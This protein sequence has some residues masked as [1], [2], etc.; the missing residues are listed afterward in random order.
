MHGGQAFLLLFAIMVILN[1]PTFVFGLLAVKCAVYLCPSLKRFLVIRWVLPII[2]GLVLMVLGIGVTVAH[3]QQP[4]PTSPVLSGWGCL[5]LICVLD[6]GLLLLLA[7]LKYRECAGKATSTTAQVAE[8]LAGTIAAASLPPGLVETVER[9]PPVARTRLAAFR[10]G[11]VSPWSGWRY[12]KQQ[13]TLWRYGL[14]PLV[15]NLLVTGLVLAMLLAIAGYFIVAIHPKFADGWLGRTVEVLTAFGVLVFALGLSAL[16]WVILQGVFCGHFYA[17]LAE[18]VELRLGMAREDIREVRFSHQIVD[19]L[20][21]AGFLASVN[22]GLLL[23]HCVPGIG[24]VLSAAGSYYYTCMTLGLDYF[25]HPLALRGKRRGER[26]S[27][28]RQHRAHTLGLGT[29]VG[30]VFFVPSVNAVLLTTVVVGA[31]LLHRRLA[32]HD[33]DR[34]DGIG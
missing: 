7:W 20:N 10:E 34:I 8:E 27:F 1:V 25:E 12:M 5:A 30:M 3:L 26:L 6:L 23:L 4:W 16:A 18:Q 28:A 11:F 22:L 21:D 32:A 24:S 29:A 9:V 14:M 17:K 31:V 15:M 2:A 33:R 13:P 19:T